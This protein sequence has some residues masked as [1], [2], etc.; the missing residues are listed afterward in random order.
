MP[1][2]LFKDELLFHDN[3]ELKGGKVR[4]LFEW[5]VHSNSPGTLLLP[6]TIYHFPLHNT[7]HIR[8]DERHKR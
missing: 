6:L 2:L 7:A 1:S 4:G 5:V 8:T 3:K